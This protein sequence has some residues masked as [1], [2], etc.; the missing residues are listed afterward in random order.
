MLDRMLLTTKSELFG[1]P[2]LKIQYLF[3]RDTSAANYGMGGLVPTNRG[4]GIEW[5]ETTT[6]SVNPV[7]SKG[8][9]LSL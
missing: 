4:T 1:F 6:K 9:D 3:K 8:V 7:L 5:L 2:S